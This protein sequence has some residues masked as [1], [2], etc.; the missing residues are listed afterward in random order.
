MAVDLAQLVRGTLSY[1][2][3]EPALDDI[4][5]ERI[6]RG[7]A[8]HYDIVGNSHSRFSFERGEGYM[9]SRA[10]D[11]FSLVDAGSVERVRDPGDNP[12]MGEGNVVPFLPRYG[13]LRLTLSMRAT[14][15]L[16]SVIILAGW[17]LIGGGWLYW[18]VAL[19]AGWTTAI[20]IV[21]RSL[22]RMLRHWLS[23][24]S[25]N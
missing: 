12:I 15:I 7:F 8:E 24:E 22:K 19:V 5:F 9:K 16:W 13:W 18:L 25:W 2:L 17:L 10:L 1:G 23:R 14:F 6:L 3:R 20:V 11:L 4:R 21:Q